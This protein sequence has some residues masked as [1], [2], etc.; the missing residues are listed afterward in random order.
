MIKVLLSCYWYYG[1]CVIKLSQIQGNLVSQFKSLGPVVVSMT[2][3]CI[4]SYIPICGSY[5]VELFGKDQEIWPYWKRCATG[6]R[7]WGFKRL[8][9]FQVCSQLPF[10]GSKCEFSAA[11]PASCLPCLL[12]C[13]LPV[14]DG[15]LTLQN[16]N[17][18]KAFL[19]LP[20]YGVLSQQRKM[21]KTEPQWRGMIVL[22]HSLR[23]FSIL[24]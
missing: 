20:N 13:S 14:G 24:M 1:K 12:P 4:G 17:P 21:T 8:M 7:V 5:L 16:C 9:P 2:L 23:Y 15:H 6:G 19:L 11:A 3:A 18:N 10:C 22:Q